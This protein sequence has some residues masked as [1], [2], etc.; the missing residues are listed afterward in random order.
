MTSDWCLG[1]SGIVIPSVA[2]G[3]LLHCGNQRVCAE[4]KRCLGAASHQAMSVL[5][6]RFLGYARNDDSAKR[7]QNSAALH[8]YLRRTNPFEP[9]ES[10]STRPP[11][12]HAIK[13]HPARGLTLN[14]ETANLYT[15]RRI[16]TSWNGSQYL[17]KV[18]L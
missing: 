15:E 18:L 5:Q 2:E 16:I 10:Y 9:V 17:K 6:Y 7:Y 14:L 4:G 1:F 12:S 13:G 8:Y 3:S 11:L